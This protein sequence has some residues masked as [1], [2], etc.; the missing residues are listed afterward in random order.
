MDAAFGV[1]SAY[2]SPT[3]C[4]II[5]TNGIQDPKTTANQLTDIEKVAAIGKKTV[6]S[7]WA[8][9]IL[10]L[11]W[12]DTYRN[13]GDTTRRSQKEDERKPYDMIS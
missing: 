5:V 2:K 4:P 13:K 8:A 1:L 7:H 9:P 3:T 10:Q 12:Y 6:E 11:S